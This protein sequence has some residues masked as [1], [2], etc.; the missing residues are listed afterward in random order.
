MRRM[1][2]EVSSALGSDEE[3]LK[4]AVKSGF[5][6]ENLLSGNGPKCVARRTDDN[7]H[8]ETVLCQCHRRPLCVCSSDL[9]AS[10]SCALQS[11]N[12]L[13]EFPTYPSVPYVLYYICNIKILPYVIKNWCYQLG[14][15]LSLIPG[16]HREYTRPHVRLH[17]SRHL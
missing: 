3:Q 6:G 12:R 10:F 15:V 5:L 16:S 11:I 1:H 8:L 9:C 4:C 2:S 14:T 17:H 7:F 13:L